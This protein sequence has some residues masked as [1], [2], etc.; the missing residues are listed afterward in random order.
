L[1][2]FRLSALYKVKRPRIK[3]KPPAELEYLFSVNSEVEGAG[4]GPRLNCGRTPDRKS[5]QGRSKIA[6][7]FNRVSRVGRAQSP[8]GAKEKIRPERPV[9][10]S[11]T[12]LDSYSRS[13]P[14]MNRWAVLERPCGTSTHDT[15]NTYKPE[16]VSPNESESATL[17]L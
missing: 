12:G 14:A 6:H 2:K 13:N 10:S 1:V 9:L 8:Q 16:E 17:L 15:L 4:G 5:R 11:L 7:G 3:M